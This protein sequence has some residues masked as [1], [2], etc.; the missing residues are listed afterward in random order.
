MSTRI[1]VVAMDCLLPGAVGVDAFAELLTDARDARGADDPRLP[2]ADSAAGSAFASR[3]GG[4]LDADDRARARA[5]SGLGPDADDARC[6]ASFVV[7]RALAGV[8]GSTPDRSRTGLVLGCYTFPTERS[9]AV[10]LPLIE[11]EVRAGLGD[12]GVATMPGR[13]PTSADPGHVDAAGSVADTVADATGL[14]GQR[15][16]LDAACASGLYAVRLACDALALGTAD[17]VVA[18]AVC[19]PDLPLLHLSF[20]DLGAYGRGASAP[21]RADSTGILTGEGAAVVVLRRLDDALRDGDDVL[22][23]IEGSALV[24]DGAGQHPLVPGQAGQRTCYDLA[25]A[26]AG[27]APTDVDYIEC[28]AT[29]TPVGD[30]TELAS[31]TAA[32]GERMPLLGS[33]KGNIGH[34]LTAAGITSLIKV[35]LAMRSGTIPPTVGS[36]TDAPFLHPRVVGAP[37][38]WPASD[39]PRRAAVSAFGFGG[40]NAHLVVSHDPA[41]ERAATA[42]TDDAGRPAG[43][44]RLPAVAVTG[45][46]AY[47]GAGARVA[48]LAHAEGSGDLA[49]LA[50]ADTVPRLAGTPADGRALGPIAL[51]PI[52]DRIP[53]R[54][55]PHL[56]PAPLAVARA[57][58]DAFADADRVDGTA[59]GAAR[60]FGSRTAVVVA[61]DLDARAHERLAHL[62]ADEL[63]ARILD[64]DDVDP[65]TVRTVRDALHSP[66]SATEVMSYIG[67]ITASRISSTWNLT[68]PSFTVSAG[69]LGVIRAVE[70]AQ[71]LLA[72]PT[73]DA[74]V[75]AGV[76][77]AVTAER[78][79]LP[80][81][82]ARPLDAA[83]AFVLRRPE[84][85][86]D[87][88]ALVDVPAAGEGPDA[89]PA[90]QA[91]D[92]H[93]PTAAE[94]AGLIADVLDAHPDATGIAV[95]S[96]RETWGD[97]ANAAAGLMLL[98][99]V[100]GIHARVTPATLADLDLPADL[101]LRLDAASSG[102]A[103]PG[104]P[105][106]AR[107][108]APRSGLIR[109]L[110]HG[111]ATA[112]LRV[113]EPPRRRPV[114]PGAAWRAGG[115]RR[116]VR[117]DAAT[118]D[119]LARALDRLADG[120]APE[121]LP[122]TPGGPE[123]VVL[124]CRDRA[125]LPREAARARDAIASLAPGARWAAPGGS[126]YAT[127]D[128]A[129]PPRIGYAFP[130]AF[131]AYPRFGADLL[132]M[133]PQAMD[134]FDAIVAES[135][136]EVRLGRLHPWRHE[137]ASPAEL[138]R[139][140]EELQRDV[141]FMLGVGTTFAMVYADLLQGVTGR[142]PTSTIG[143]SLGASSM[144]FATRR[145]DRH[146]RALRR[147]IAS[148]V[149]Q[150]ELAGEL[151]TV[152]RAFGMDAST[153]LAEVWRAVVVLAPADEVAARVAGS[154]R[155]HVTHVNTPGEVVVAGP[156]A[157][158]HA[159][160]HESGFRTAPSPVVS[161]LH[162]PLAE[163]WADEL[164]A[165]HRFPLGEGTDA[166]LLDSVDGRP[167]PPTA[168]EEELARSIARSVIEPVD[169]PR[170]ARAIAEHADLVLE[171]GPGGTCAR[172]IT[173]TAVPGLRAL[174]PDHRGA[175]F[176]STW[177]AFLAELITQGVDVEIEAFGLDPVPAP[178]TGPLVGRTTS[179]RHDVAAAFAR[180]RT[181]ER[182][183]APEPVPA[184]APEPAVAPEPARLSWDPRAAALGP[185]WRSGAASPAVPTGSRGEIADLVLHGRQQLV[186]QV[187]RAHRD[188]L[189]FQHAM[190]VQAAR[191]LPEDPA[192]RPAVAPPAPDRASDPAPA[193][194]DATAT[195][196]APAIWD[197]HDLL[198]FATGDIARVFGP[199]Y[200]EIDGF[201]TRVRL[202]APPYH[203][204][205]R[206]VDVQG[207][208]GRFERSTITTEYDVPLDAW[209]LVDDGVPA[210]V[211]IEAGQGDLLLVSWLG[212]DVE[213][214]GLRTYRL[215]DSTLV[216]H[217]DLPRAGQTLRYEITI[218][219][220]I[221]NGPT[222]LFYFGYRCY[223]DGVL[224][225]ELTKATA[226]FFS[227]EE[228]EAPLGILPEPAGPEVPATG[229]D[230]PWRKPVEPTDH[231]EL[232]AADLARLAAG[233]VAGVFGPRHGQPAG[234][235]PG[236]RLPTAQ[237]R[238]IDRLEIDPEGGTHRLGKVTAHLDLDPDGWYFRC[239]FTDDPVLA[240]SLVAEGAVQA[241][242]V[243][244]LHEGFHLV[245]PDARFQTI[246]GIHTDVAV[247]GQIVPGDARL[248]YELDIRELTLLPRPTVI[249]DVLV[250]RDDQP[251]VRMRDFG[252]QIREK[253][254]SPYRP[255][256]GGRSPFL[257]RLS[258]RGV[259]T[260]VNELQLAHAAR[261]DLGTAM[262]PEFD[263]Y[264][265]RRAPHIPNRDFQFVDRIESVTGERGR[266][267]PGM[268]M[269]SE[270][271]AHADSWYYREN[272]A[273]TM[274]HAV[275]LESSLQAAILLGYYQGATL[276]QP[277][278]EFAIRNLDGS[279]ELVGP[280]PAPG[281]TIRQTTTLLFSSAVEGNVLQKFRYELEGDDGV[282]YRGESVFG[283]FSEQALASQTGLDAGARTVPRSLAAG[284]DAPDL[285]LDAAALDA[286][287]RQRPD[288]LALPGGR[289]ALL[290]EVRIHLDQ[291]PA[292]LGSIWGRRDVTPDDWYFTRH[293][294]RDPVQPGSLGI[295][296]MLQ[297]LQVLA[298]EKGL[299][300]GFRDPRIEL[301][302]GVSTT[303]TYRGQVATTDTD[304]QVEV[305]ITR[306]DREPDSVTVVADS[307]LWKG[308]LRIYAVTGLAIRI[309]DDT[310]DTHGIP[311]TDR[312]LEETNHD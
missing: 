250:F 35:V 107:R 113:V 163:E 24:N 126:R 58:G 119:D 180:V 275:I 156:A 116:I 152:R 173:D 102:E 63:L 77:L 81:A 22:A 12:A 205:S 42:A 239:H 277:T 171:A 191:T 226:G 186:R 192:T 137:A 289:L 266:L 246:P 300:D 248:R 145:W 129:N 252:V 228:L 181:A 157:D 278:V 28:H 18:G 60:R 215:L 90:P 103:V 175:P 258:S 177:P 170:L 213:N 159:L 146:R 251:V 85:T 255:G 11:E 1:A 41:G 262:G 241:L 79:L 150:D 114:D 94:R 269:V 257:G 235:N 78:A 30:R 286:R 271:D 276:D 25:Y 8:G 164:V 74:V 153:P 96:T 14:G 158:V 201:A 38:P 229:P 284:S 48:D 92:V 7:R 80:G 87:A 247:R 161:P 143:Y 4:F 270:Y 10:S 218:E 166:L 55:I 197:E 178:P 111:G 212:I 23:V 29:G 34:L 220:F 20:S 223:A 199:E 13:V 9:A 184:A 139:Y 282:F 19:A 120:A 243:L 216:F 221:R 86:A 154:P 135:S 27:L 56:N 245:L 118:R 89:G 244:L 265:D 32:F 122:A 209:Y 84:D 108:D 140:E 148:P 50:G 272:P 136:E 121:D 43:S 280:F 176:G 301:A 109:V 155:L 188:T 75:V 105:W 46:G 240:G 302:Q 194:A 294:H 97:A 292:G 207:E 37:T 141:P 151:L 70:A 182:E 299:V 305:D 237:L 309:H 222:T 285:V 224:I 267:A 5:E 273:G 53:P 88:Y 254:G 144:L 236:L 189:R 261:G 210:A 295:E 219:R 217:G 98:R 124:V 259:P 227:R 167:I 287:H 106:L 101:R 233:D 117:L 65:G 142:A 125:A 59:E 288:R 91:V 238:M 208:R 3:R 312:T 104:T 54:D 31:L 131:T 110:G 263:V 200:A 16:V 225:L 297:A 260:V 47:V 64:E 82:S 172:W 33:V 279:A 214:R 198:E 232:D 40:A 2:R 303:W 268:V 274:P 17:T 68:G 67:S 211:T 206:V 203:F 26:D 128:P 130:G 306:V 162:S 168:E 231:H 204:V 169:F 296:S 149:F 195:T 112:A 291:G 230:R 15:L 293:F 133:L 132:R 249:A 187:I 100:L 298:V 61:L 138:M 83:T 39:G 99:T 95:T 307:S 185:W 308:D 76:D 93:A 160:V 71:L 290:D 73:I 45:V 6:W 234:A 256:T 196:P 123:R 44:P 311:T 165:L 147:I 72:D 52:G 127:V 281:S 66:L 193:P 51:D 264:G 174:A 253:E 49:A 57:V 134:A 190:L 115:G 179:I 69:P 21:F 62:R 242:Q 310:T 304:C 283:Y 183:A 36:A 202:P